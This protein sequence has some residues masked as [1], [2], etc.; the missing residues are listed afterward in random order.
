MV[1][2]LHEF[3]DSLPNRKLTKEISRTAFLLGGH[4]SQSLPNLIP[5]I[6]KRFYRWRGFLYGV[7]E[8][9]WWATLRLGE[10]RRLYNIFGFEHSFVF[11]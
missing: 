11:Y 5:F 1:S 9:F 2:A 8:E 4:I 6:G 7:I 3:P 10:D